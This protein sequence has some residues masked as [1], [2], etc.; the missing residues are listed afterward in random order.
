[1]YPGR[2]GGP[3]RV[4]G[5]G[6]PVRGSH[7]AVERRRGRLAAQPPFCPAGVARLARR[8]AAAPDPGG[9]GRNTGPGARPGGRSPAGGVGPRLLL[10]V[11]AV[12]S[13]ARGVLPGGLPG[14]GAPGGTG[15]EEARRHADTACGPEPPA[16]GHLPCL[17]GRGTPEGP[18]RGSRGRPVLLPGPARAGHPR[19]LR[20]GSAGLSVRTGLRGP[21]GAGGVRGGARAGGHGPPAARP[22]PSPPVGDPHRP[23]LR[24]AGRGGLFPQHPVHRRGGRVVRG[25]GGRAHPAGDGGEPNPPGPP[26]PDHDRDPVLPEP[27]GDPERRDPPGASSEAGSRP[28]GPC[29]CR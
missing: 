2:P 29:S 28:T 5:G 20:P 26:H 3:V 25:L 19:L 17:R 15:V 12:S 13:G 4:R 9:G 6:R 16:P 8:R 21:G 1:V 27:V 23:G 11:P 22:H 18:R 24:A 10:P 7:P 14:A